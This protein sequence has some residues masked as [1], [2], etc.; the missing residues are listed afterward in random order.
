MSLRD[1]KAL[2]GVAGGG[3][4][5]GVAGG[6]VGPPVDGGGAPAMVSDDDPPQPASISVSTS[7]IR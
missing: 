1:S 3:F 4:V 5:G 7:T 2:P 6:G